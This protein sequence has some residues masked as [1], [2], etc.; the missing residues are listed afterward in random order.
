MSAESTVADSFSQNV[1]I[2]RL[3][4]LLSTHDSQGWDL[5]W[6]QKALLFKHITYIVSLHRKQQITPWDARKEQAEP[7]LVEIVESGELSSI[8]GRAL[9]PGCG[10]VR[11]EKIGDNI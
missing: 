9:I 2:Q 4:T 11:V 7:P 8:K 6:Y 10:R 3:R 1:D 5:A